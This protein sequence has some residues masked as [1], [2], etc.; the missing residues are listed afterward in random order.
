MFCA[1]F[2]RRRTAVAF[3]TSNKIYSQQNKLTFLRSYQANERDVT[4]RG[5]VSRSRGRE[6]RH[7]DTSPLY[8]SPPHSPQRE[9]DDSKYLIGSQTQLTVS[10]LVDR[11]ASKI[12]ISLQVPNRLVWRHSH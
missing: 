12:Y 5:G 7:G 3:P 11:I 8:A 9:R 4:L 1:Y 6:M 10:V 2:R